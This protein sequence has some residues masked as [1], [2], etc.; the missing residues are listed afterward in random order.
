M[1]IT[2]PYT[3]ES[4]LSYFM[5]GYPLI[6]PCVLLAL[7]IGVGCS[8]RL[9]AWA[10][11]YVDD[12][13]ETA[14]NHGRQFLLNVLGLGNHKVSSLLPI[15]CVSYRRDTGPPLRLG[16]MVSFAGVYYVK[17]D[18]YYA[19]LVFNTKIEAE[20]AISLIEE[21]GAKDA[22]CLIEQEKGKPV[23]NERIIWTL[24]GYLTGLCFVLGAYKFIP[25]ITVGIAIGYAVLR[26]ARYAVRTKK[27][28]V[29][30]IADTSVH[31]SASNDHKIEE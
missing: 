18:R 30:H 21:L 22:Y 19:Y 12:S 24:L 10:L 14:V 2:N 5:S 9:L 3:L 26:L 8:G 17:F 25:E 1:E 27:R 15:P 4:F 13:E 7:A 11:E 6:V 16:N 31:V 29:A 23:D 28:I 20:Q